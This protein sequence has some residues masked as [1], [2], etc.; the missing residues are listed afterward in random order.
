MRFISY[1]G[2]VQSTALIVLVANGVLT[3]DKAVFA[4]TGDDSEHPATLEYV[5]TV[6]APYAAEAGVPI[7]ELR[8]VIRGKEQTLY[9]YVIKDKISTRI[10]IRMAGGAPGN[11]ACTSEWKIGVID[12]YLTWEGFD[13]WVRA[14]ALVGI[15]ADEVQ[16]LSGRKP[17]KA[18]DPEYPLVDLGLTR[19]DCAE[20]IREAGLPVPPKSSCWFCP[21]K[22]RAQWSEMKLV[23]P[24]LFAKAVEME[25]TINKHRAE[26]GRDEAYFSSFLIPLSD[27]PVSDDSL[28]D[29][30][31]DT[32]YCMV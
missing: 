3:A 29:D 4:N 23:E 18:H 30:P 9:D 1:G 5:R 15:S 22:S 26:A 12:R 11:R 20:I 21:M 19:D 28:T 31:C 24:E 14:T 27:I 13:E 2:G 10:P 8:R 32:G 25:A 17:G 6:A 16:R 7:V